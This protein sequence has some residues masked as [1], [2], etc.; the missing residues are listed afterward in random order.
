MRS[1]QQ[2]IGDPLAGQKRAFKDALKGVRVQ[3]SDNNKISLMQELQTLISSGLG[4]SHMGRF[5]T[6]TDVLLG[7]FIASTPS[8]TAT[9]DPVLEAVKKIK[10]DMQTRHAANKVD[11][12][13]DIYLK[14]LD[15]LNEDLQDIGKGFILHETTKFYQ[16]LEKGYWYNNNKGFS[17]REMSL[18]NYIDAI[19]QFGKS[20]GINTNWLKFAAYNLSPN[21]LGSG[22]KAPLESYF[23]IMAG[24]IMFDD[25]AIIAQEVTEGLQ[26][27]NVE[28]VHLYSLQG[29]YFP[30]SYFLQETY[31]RM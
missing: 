30:A 6:G 12:M 15:T 11:A 29:I 7:Q 22:L 21:A 13:S 10:L 18:L 27:S 23:A 25:F 4:G 28:A 9:R 2:Q 26:Y 17:G 16:T 14:Q 1:L 8:T 3:W 5:Q 31:N 20:F 24:L 19:G